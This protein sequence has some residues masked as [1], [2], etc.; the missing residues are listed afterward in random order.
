MPI[1]L[2]LENEASDY[3]Q[4]ISNTMQHFLLKYYKAT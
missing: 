1:N 4:G 3:V 2:Y